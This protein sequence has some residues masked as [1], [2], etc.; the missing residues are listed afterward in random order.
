MKKRIEPVLLAAALAA[1]VLAQSPFPGSLPGTPIDPRNFQCW[2][3]DLI[4]NN[5]TDG[6]SIQFL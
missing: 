2:Y 5:F 6:I 4:T 3:R 1:P